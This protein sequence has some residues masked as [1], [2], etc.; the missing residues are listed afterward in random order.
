MKIYRYLFMISI[1]AD[2]GLV[3]CFEYKLKGGS[4]DLDIAYE[5]NMLTVPKSLWSKFKVLDIRFGSDFG[6]KKDFEEND[7]KDLYFFFNALQPTTDLKAYDLS[8]LIDLVYY[9]DYLNL[10]DWRIMDSILGE[11]RA[12]ITLSEFEKL[13]LNGDIKCDL[14]LKLRTI[15][16]S[17]KGAKD[18]YWSPQ[19]NYYLIKGPAG[20]TQLYNILGEAQ[21]GPLT[22]VSNI[23]WS[24]NGD[25]YWVIF[26]NHRAE[27]YDASG[28]T[29]NVRHS[30]VTD[31]WWSPSGEHYIVRF[32]EGLDGNG[33]VQL[34]NALGIAQGDSLENVNDVWWS[35]TGESY[36]VRLGN[37]AIHMPEDDQA[38]LYSIDGVAQGDPIKNVNDVWWSSNGDVYWIKF[39]DKHAELYNTLGE[40]QG[41]SLSH[42]KSI[43]WSPTS[44][45]YWIIFED[46]SAQLY[47]ISGK[48]MGDKILKVNHIWWSPTGNSCWIGFNDNQARLYNSIGFLE[49]DKLARVINIVWSSN[50][51]KYAV[52]KKDLY[53]RDTELVIYGVEESPYK[54]EN[55]GNQLLRAATLNQ[56]TDDQDEDDF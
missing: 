26:V 50:D 3:D 22:E 10:E 40:L 49:G 8:K 6:F 34:Y 13:H 51:Y 2:L 18:I 53:T 47:S 52:L 1:L 41:E 45:S 28:F 42:V 46:Y 9:A 17:V 16:K 33:Y 37:R 31:I 29:R 35:P 5:D 56:E 14:G 11:I 21:G 19:D 24:P 20:R 39:N 38:Q 15:L 23:I 44:G 54:N 32:E 36:W 7:L 4:L 55:F 48:K 30:K 12:R 43:H 25:K 27:L